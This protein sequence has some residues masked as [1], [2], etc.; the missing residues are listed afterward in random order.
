M[1]AMRWALM[2]A[3]LVFAIPAQAGEADVV[4]VELTKQGEDQFRFNVT[5]RHADEGWDHYADRWEVV[6]PDGAVLGT[7]E[8]AHPHV[9]E[10]PF[11]RSLSSVEIPAG[12]SEVT[13]RARD[14]VHG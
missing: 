11:T 5:V 10:Q 13:I 4:D 9:D 14:S 6:G 12:V 2:I 7:R 3:A 1:P 8:L